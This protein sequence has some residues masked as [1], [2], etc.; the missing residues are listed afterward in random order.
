MSF[1]QD[2]RL[3]ILNTLL[4]PGRANVRTSRNSCV[5]RQINALVPFPLG[6]TCSR[7]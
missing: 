2:L 4:C 7:R 6:Y 1:E 3:D 5:D